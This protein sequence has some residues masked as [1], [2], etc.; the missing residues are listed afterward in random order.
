MNNSRSGM[1]IQKVH[2]FDPENAV[3]RPRVCGECRTCAGGL[4]VQN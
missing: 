2:E 1:L 3:E 4:A